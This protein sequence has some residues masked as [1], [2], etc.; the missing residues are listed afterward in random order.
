MLLDLVWLGGAAGG[1]R[2]LVGGKAAHLCRLAARYPVPAGFCLTTQAFRQ[3]RAAAGPD[4]LPRGVRTT[5]AKAYRDLGGAQGTS[6]PAVAV[7]SSAVDEDGSEASFAGQH[8]TFLHLRGLAAVEA[9]VLRCWRSA[10]S[11]RALHYRRQRG[12]S[13]EGTGLAV[14]VQLMV[15]ADVAFVAFS[16]D[17]VD[18]RRDRAVINANWGLG[19]SIVGGHATPDTYVVQKASL[20]LVSSRIGSKER[21]TVA[22]A[23]GTTE[24]ATPRILRERRAL[25]GEQV[26]SITRLLLELEADMEGP[27]DVEGAI[28]QDRIYLLQ[29]RAVTRLGPADA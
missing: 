23:V 24:V 26:G 13:P 12:L 25:T 6:D 9:A 17:P 3:W 21:M 14:L 29:C 28:A 5:L 22:T 7:R 2:L 8:D 10:A 16:V 19:E 15:A 4:D 20:D 18:G 1:D 11:Q 27:V